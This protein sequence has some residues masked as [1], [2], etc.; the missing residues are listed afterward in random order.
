MARGAARAGRI[1]ALSTAV[2]IAALGLLLGPSPT[3]TSAAPTQSCTVQ[4]LVGGDCPTTTE[5][6]LT[7]TT[8]AE[9][10][11]TTSTARPTSATAFETTTTPEDAA[12][13]TTTT[14][15]TA[16]SVNLLIPGD[17]TKG[18]ESTTTTEATATSASDGGLHD[19]SLIAIMIVGLVLVGGVVAVLT[20]RYWVAT[21]P[22]LLGRD[23]GSVPAG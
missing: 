11:S 21:R 5:S 18:A 7:T 2:T 6:G 19:G 10:E 3:A 1:L 8:I 16:T 14:V 13:E 20:W 15:G 22:P 4:T 17:G 9:E 23:T 12:Q